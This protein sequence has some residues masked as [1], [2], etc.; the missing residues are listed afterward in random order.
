MYNCPATNITAANM[1]TTVALANC[2]TSLMLLH[3]ISPMARYCQENARPGVKFHGLAGFRENRPLYRD[4]GAG[5]I[6]SV[7]DARTAIRSAS[8]LIVA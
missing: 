4:A 1:I 7:R 6:S 8:D 5:G 2:V 3:Q